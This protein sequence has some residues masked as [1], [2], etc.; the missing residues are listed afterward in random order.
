MSDRPSRADEVTGARGP[1]AW[2]TRR[3]PLPHRRNDPIYGKDGKRIGTRSYVP[4]I[5]SYS[6]TE[7]PWVCWHFG[8]TNDSLWPPWRSTRLLGHVAVEME[9]AVCGHREVMAARIRRFGHPNPTGR[10]HPIR[11]QFK[12][13]HLHRDRGSPM[14]W[15]KPLLNPAAHKGGIDLDALAMR[16]EADLREATLDRAES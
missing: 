6:D 12:L 11:T 2:W 5:K 7:R 13:D 3:L 16:L 8:R 14:S 10:E 9:C 4:G 1:L 15:A